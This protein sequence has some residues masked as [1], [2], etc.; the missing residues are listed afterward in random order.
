[1]PWAVGLPL[2]YDVIVVA[3]TLVTCCAFQPRR[4]HCSPFYTFEELF[5]GDQLY[6]YPFSHSY[7]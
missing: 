3:D 4:Q 5:N 1:M 7:M 6:S 2:F